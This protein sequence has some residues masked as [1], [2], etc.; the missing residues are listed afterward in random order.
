MHK[1]NILKLSVVMCVSILMTACI[2]MNNK[3]VPIE[4]SLLGNST[5]GTVA[6]TKESSI[7]SKDIVAKLK[8]A[9]EKQAAE[10]LKGSKV[11]NLKI[12]IKT[13]QS[14]DD[15]VGGAA[16]GKLIGS[17]TRL[18]GVVTVTNK[19]GTVLGKYKIL[20]THNE[21][22]LLGDTQTFSFVDVKDHVVE[23]FAMFTVYEL[24]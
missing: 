23:K 2:D 8:S 19:K 6:I 4:K 16:M 9:I 15:M 13:W 1:N 10:K 22:G 17:G 12:D 20:S 3:I 11:V 21:S 24:E 7:K 5:L 14:P 18:D